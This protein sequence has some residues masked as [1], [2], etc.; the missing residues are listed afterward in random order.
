MTLYDMGLVPFEEPFP[1]IRLGGLIIHNGARMSKS[2]GNVVDPDRYID[3][4]G[5]DV[6]RTFLLFTGPWEVGG[7]FIDRGIVG[8]ERFFARVWRRVDRGDEG[9][10][11]PAPVVERVS[12]AIERLRFNVAIAALMG[13]RDEVDP[14]T[15]AFLRPGSSSTRP[16]R[17]RTT[18]STST[19]HSSARTRR[20][21]ASTILASPRRPRCCSFC[22]PMA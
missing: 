18:T 7:D 2:R 21:K 9:T 6:L 3:E 14:A 16:G 13:A 15:M 8:I 17:L 19:C 12:S 10:I 4:H 11:E 20:S 1:F 22:A 5:A